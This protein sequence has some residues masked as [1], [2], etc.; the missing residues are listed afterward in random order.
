MSELIRAASGSGYASHERDTS[1][2]G[3]IKA[4]DYMF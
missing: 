1:G 3:V 2:A 4:A